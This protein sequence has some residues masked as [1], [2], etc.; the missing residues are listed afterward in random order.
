[1]VDQTN[2]KNTIRIPQSQKER[3]QK[4]KKGKERKEGRSE[5][6]RKGGMKTR[7]KGEKEGKTFI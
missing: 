6:G 5:K 1:M 4:E 3:K 2:L 7:R